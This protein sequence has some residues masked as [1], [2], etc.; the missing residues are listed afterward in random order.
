MPARK[1]PQKHPSPPVRQVLLRLPQEVYDAV[2]TLAQTEDRRVS[3]QIIRLLRQAL[4]CQ[5]SPG[6]SP[7]P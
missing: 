6:P 1:H 7:P 2:S 4:T 5:K 3:A